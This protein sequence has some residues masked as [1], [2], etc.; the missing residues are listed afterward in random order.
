MEDVPLLIEA[1][2]GDLIKRT[3]KPITG[4]SKSAM[5]LFLGYSWMGNVREL[6]SALEFAFVVA[7]SGPIEPHHLPNHLLQNQQAPEAFTELEETEPEGKAALM[8][9]LKEANGNRT[10]AAKILGVTRATVW[11]RINKYNIKVEQ[12]IKVA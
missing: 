6:K 10:K 9:A 2:V 1:I 5:D 11:N 7:E 4:L 12:V 3:W 8:A